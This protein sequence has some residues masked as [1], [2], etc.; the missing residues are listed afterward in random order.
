MH[1]LGEFP[2]FSL[3]PKCFLSLILFVTVLTVV[4]KSYMKSIASIRKKKALKKEFVLRITFE[5]LSKLNRYATDYIA[6]PEDSI[7]T[8]SLKKTLQYLRPHYNNAKV[9]LFC[10]SSALFYFYLQHTSIIF[11]SDHNLQIQLSRY[12]L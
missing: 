5:T 11:Q 12:I 4:F 1:S 7:S 9:S 3:I 2:S 10:S 6:T 8:K